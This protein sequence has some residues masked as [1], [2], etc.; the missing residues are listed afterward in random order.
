M[1]GGSNGYDM[2]DA[3][4]GGYGKSN[5]ELGLTLVSNE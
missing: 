1:K 2:D 3:N 4:A 5:N